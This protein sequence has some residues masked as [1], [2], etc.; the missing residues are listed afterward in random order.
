MKRLDDFIKTNRNDA[1][2]ACL[3]EE[4]KKVPNCDDDF[5]LGVLVYTKNDDDKKEMIKFIQ[6]GE[7]VTYEQVVLNALW[8]NQQR[9]NKQIMSDTADD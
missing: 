1:L 8:L 6:K 2:S 4:L 3:I 7:D 9:K 5:I